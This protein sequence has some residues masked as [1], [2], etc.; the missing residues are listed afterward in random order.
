MPVKLKYG[1]NLQ[2]LPLGGSSADFFWNQKLELMSLREKKFRITSQ[3][4]GVF[5][6]FSRFRTQ[7][8]ACPSSVHL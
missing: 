8:H 2:F 1:R 3:S 4:K 5:S 6:S 7:S